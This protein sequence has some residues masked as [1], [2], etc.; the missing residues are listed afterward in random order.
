MSEASHTSTTAGACACGPC[1]AADESQAQKPRLPFATAWL[2]QLSEELCNV[3]D[4]AGLSLEY[5]QAV[6]TL[7]A[8][9]DHLRIDTPFAKTMVN[10]LNLTLTHIYRARDQVG[11]KL[12]ETRERILIAI[13]EARRQ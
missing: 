8:D 4:E 1:K 6:L 13:S 9:S 12:V 11:V 7:A 3:E 5:A 10:A 2:E